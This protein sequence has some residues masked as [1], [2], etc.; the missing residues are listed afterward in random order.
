MSKQAH[1]L[2]DTWE[3]K[4]ASAPDYIRT[5]ILYPCIGV[6][7]Y[8]VEK[9]IALVA[10]YVDPSI[11]GLEELIHRAQLELKEIPQQKVYIAGGSPTPDDD[12]D[13]A[14]DQARKEF[15]DQTFAQ[16]GY[17]KEQIYLKYNQANENSTLGIDTLTGE[18]KHKIWKSKGL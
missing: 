14:S 18:I 13:N 11:D 1:I 12:P 5:T 17:Q 2:V 16:A 10:H 9:K 8:Q 4:K 3:T 6:I 15:V 7:I